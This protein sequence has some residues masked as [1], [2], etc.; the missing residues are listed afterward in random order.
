M[1]PKKVKFILLI[2]M[3][4]C[5][6]L[7]TA[8]KAYCENEPQ[9][10]KISIKL[11]YI[12]KVVKPGEKPISLLRPFLSQILPE[13]K[14]PELLSFDDLGDKDERDNFI[15]AG[16]TFVV[17]GD[18]KKDGNADIA[19]V[20]KDKGSIL[21]EK[22]IYLVVISIKEQTVTRD[23]FCML[24]NKRASLLLMANYKK[25]PDVIMVYY[26]LESDWCHLLYWNGQKYTLQSCESG[27]DI[28]HNRS[29]IK[30]RD[31]ANK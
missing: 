25:G 26:N 23:F 1:K 9:N 24:N 17:R 3:W 16:C 10:R 14:E 7:S 2:F 19:F 31:S 6:L 13:L 30:K 18:F 15:E 21:S 28:K 20:V 8:D 4:C 27:N 11:N 22:K 12:P 29:K 5:I